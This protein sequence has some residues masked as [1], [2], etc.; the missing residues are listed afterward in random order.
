MNKVKKLAF[1]VLLAMTLTVFVLNNVFATPEF[2]T[3]IQ[4]TV[5]DF[6][7]FQAQLKNTK[8]GRLVAAKINSFLKSV[9]GLANFP[10]ELC[11][12]KVKSSVLKL[13]KAILLLDKKTCQGNRTVG[14]VPQDLVLGFN[15]EHVNFQ[16]KEELLNFFLTDSDDD[17][18]IDLCV[19]DTDRDTIS[20]KEDNCP[21]VSNKLQKDTNGNGIGDACDLFTCCDFSGI[22][23]TRD[24]CDKKTIR[25]C[26]EEDRVIID[27]TGALKKGD[28]TSSSGTTLTSFSVIREYLDVAGEP[29]SSKSLLFEGDSPTPGTDG[30]T[31]DTTM[32]E[33]DEEFERRLQEAINMSKVPS[34]EY[35]EDYDCDDFAGDLEQELEGQGFMATFTAIWTD[36]GSDSVP[37]HAL[38]DVH[39]PSG[40]LVWVEPQTGEIVDLD[41]D[42]DGEVM[43]SDGSHNEDFMA[44]EGMSQIEVYEDKTSASMAGVPVD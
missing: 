18:V 30:M 3:Q 43:A 16:D 39:A 34:M 13:N 7:N 9:N 15:P 24:S 20:N 40:M 5:D 14:C 36:D 33:T 26:R 22:D 11:E 37:G 31:G 2:I 19:N 12:R 25:Q 6:N 8:G 44:T 41:E 35:G 17:G 42:G 32:A 1:R 29:V 4:D 38:T 28:S 27:C 21:Y 10:P 23:A